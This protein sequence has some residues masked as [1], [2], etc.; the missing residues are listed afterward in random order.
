MKSIKKKKDKRR[1][2]QKSREGHRK[3]KHG[4][5]GLK[6]SG[7]TISPS[8]WVCSSEERRKMVMVFIPN[9][10]VNNC[11]HGQCG[12][13]DQTR[14]CLLDYIGRSLCENCFHF[15][16]TYMVQHLK[17]SDCKCFRKAPEVVLHVGFIM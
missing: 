9:K 3:S 5:L 7:V 4:N 2:E 12:D 6:R 13:S 17:V 1:K 8:L 11:C 15:K 10:V 16:I 14:L